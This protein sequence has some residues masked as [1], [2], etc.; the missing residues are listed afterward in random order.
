MSFDEKNMRCYPFLTNYDAIME[1]VKSSILVD[2]SHITKIEGY[3]KKIQQLFFGFSKQKQI[4][5]V[6]QKMIALLHN[7]LPTAK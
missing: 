2:Y 5:E 3:F 4:D 7:S 1:F 6:G